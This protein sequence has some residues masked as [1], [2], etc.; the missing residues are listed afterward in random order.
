M[1]DLDLTKIS[2][3]DHRANRGVLQK[4]GVPAL[5]DNEEHYRDLVEN[6]FDLMCTH[7]FDGLILSVNLASARTLGYEPH[8]IVNRNIREFLS[9]QSYQEFDAFLAAIH[10]QSIFKGFL[11]LLTKSGET[12]IWRFTSTVKSDGAQARFVRGA[13]HDVTDILQAQKALR[14]SE[15]RLR[16]AA[17][18]GRMYAWEWDPA[19]DLVLRSAES[20]DILGLNGATIDG[21]GKDYFNFVHPDDRDRVWDLATS[22][23][24]AVQE[25]R[26]EYRRYR[27]DGTMLWLQESGHATFDKAGKMIR[28]V[29][30]TADITERKRANEAL[31]ASEERNRQLVRESPIA[32][33]VTHGLEQKNELV[34]ERFT[35]IF[36]YSIEDVP[37]VAE[38]WSLAYPEKAYREK[39]RR[40]W[41]ARVA[42]AIK[43]RST[44][45]PMEAKV[46]CKDGS[47][48][49]VEFHFASLG[50]TNL[51]SLVDLTERKNAQDELAKVG[52]RLI[53]A[54]EQERT[55]IGRELHD[56]IGQQLAILGIGLANLDELLLGSSA[57]VRSHVKKLQKRVSE[58]STDVGAISQELH[59]SKLELLGLNVAVRSLCQEFARFYKVKIDFVGRD[60]PRQLPK[61]ISICLFRVAQEALS[62]GVKHSR[63]GQFVVQLVG[64]PGAIHLSVRDDGVGFDPENTM[65]RRGLGLISM[66]ERLTL[67]RGTVEIRSKPRGGT[68]IFCSVPSAN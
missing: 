22:L 31:Q 53:E 61:D 48:R 68:E 59:S 28:L 25:Y 46:R 34:N 40:E 33:L 23:T 58:I 6:S 20:V 3:L 57:K 2:E 24:P 27:P 17:A 35:A 45:A 18:V 64:M 19:T 62:N 52:G 66:R 16:V 50:E 54:Q 21:V 26:T 15:E 44:I 12:R 32:M 43:T 56:D 5:R 67:V 8:E 29:G 63:G 9:P 42:E 51:V 55:R 36:G 10:K 14:R 41:Q 1:A 4:T 7:D 13:A 65:N 39:I 47:Y 49:Y 11:R 60:L 37:S 30:M 38:W